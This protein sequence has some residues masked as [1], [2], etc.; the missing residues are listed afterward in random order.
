MKRLGTISCLAALAAFGISTVANAQTSDEPSDVTLILH[1]NATSYSGCD[2]LNLADVTC[3]TIDATGGAMAGGAMLAFLIVGGIPDFVPG[4]GS[5]DDSGGIGAVQFGIEYDPT[6]QIINAALCT[7][8]AEIGQN[9]GLGV[10][11][12]SGTGNAVT[13]SGGCI[14]STDN[15]DNM[16]KVMAFTVASPTGAGTLRVTGDPR[17]PID[18]AALFTDCAAVPARVCPQSWGSLTMSGDPGF[19]PCGLTCAV[20]VKGTSWTE[21]KSLF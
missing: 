18:G 9:D 20:P 8:G 3:G 19:N 6:I 4:G 15:D 12:A 21:V 10:W 16:L 5:G 13:W 1:G 14:K 7:G 11:P 17:A 2:A